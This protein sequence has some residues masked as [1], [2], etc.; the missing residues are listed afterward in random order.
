LSPHPASKS[1]TNNRIPNSTMRRI[2]LP[3]DARGT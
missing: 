3:P 2:D 1:P